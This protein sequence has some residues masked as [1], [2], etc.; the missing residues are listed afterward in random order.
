MNYPV[1]H[2]VV[3][4]EVVQLRTKDTARK[5]DASPVD[6]EMDD[7]AEHSASQN[8]ER[9]SRPHCYFIIVT[10]GWVVNGVRRHAEPLGD[11]DPPQLSTL[12]CLQT[13]EPRDV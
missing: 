6:E 2:P 13:C 12:G 3:Q 5:H 7:H 10:Q 8:A 9:P 11:N 1:R 4:I